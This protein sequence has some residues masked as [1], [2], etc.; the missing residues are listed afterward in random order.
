VTRGPVRVLELRSTH[1][2]GGGPDKTI[3]LSAARHDPERIAVRVVYLRGAGDLAFADGIGARARS[4]GVPIVEV[5]ERGRLDRAAFRELR[6]LARDAHVVHAHE[7]RTDVLALL[8]RPR[9]ARLL[10]TAHGWTLESRKMRA[11]AAIDRLALRAYD[12]VIAVSRA[13][14]RALLAARVP[15]EKITLLHN[16]IDAE[17]WRPSRAPSR[18]DVVVVGCLTRLSREKGVDRLVKA[19]AL[20]REELARLG[21]PALEVLVAGD[22]PERDALDAL[23]RARGASDI[24]RFVGHAPDP[25]AFLNAADVLALPSRIENLP[26]ALLEGMATARACVAFDVG[27]VRETL[28][29]AGILVVDGDIAS[30]GRALVRLAL[31]PGLRATLGALAR[32]RVETRFRFDARLAR[33]EEIYEDLAGVERTP[34]TVVCGSVGPH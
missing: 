26:N 7:T 31:E 10:A 6:A 19:A 12:R 27:G 23:A 16:A 13:T 33:I 17:T 30:F 20:A 29:S 22:G 11:Y 34:A 8:A 2:S 24:L 28:G 21:G 5:L 25:L 9:G 1:S 4:L 32:A 3:L 14:R 15:R 18:R